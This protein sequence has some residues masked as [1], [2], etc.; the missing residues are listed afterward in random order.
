MHT[1]TA[2]AFLDPKSWKREEAEEK[3]KKKAKRG[4]TSVSEPWDRL[5]AARQYMWACFL[6]ACASS[7][8]LLTCAFV[9]VFFKILS[10]LITQSV[11]HFV[12]HLLVLPCPPF[13]PLPA[14]SILCVRCYLFL[15]KIFFIPCICL[16]NLC[17]QLACNRKYWFLLNSLL[18]SF[19]SE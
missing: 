3:E 12:S 14:P 13:S 17:A 11:L 18:C 1:Y 10:R 2:G 15:H 19:F 9:T 16:S 6:Q 4:G 7:V 8:I 5:L